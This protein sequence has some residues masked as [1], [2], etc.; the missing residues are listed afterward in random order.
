MNDCGFN[1]FISIAR[2]SDLE[3]GAPPI[4]DVEVCI[5][6]EGVEIPDGGPTGLKVATGKDTAGDAEVSILSFSVIIFINAGV[7]V[8]LIA[9]VIIDVT[10]ADNNGGSTVT[11]FGNGK[12]DAT[13]ADGVE[14]CTEAGADD[15]TVAD[16]LAY[17][18]WMTE[19]KVEDNPVLLFVAALLKGYITDIDSI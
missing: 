11:P 2:N 4:G 5:A 1:D 10:A 17:K 3:P 14:G 13:G 12:P 15:S 6:V 9:T 8:D 19:K 7:M 18:E 16:T